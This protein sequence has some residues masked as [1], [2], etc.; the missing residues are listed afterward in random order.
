MPKMPTGESSASSTELGST[1]NIAVLS[2]QLAAAADLADS[3]IFH[4]DLPRDVLILDDRAAELF[5]FGSAGSQPFAPLALRRFPIINRSRVLTKIRCALIRDGRAALSFMTDHPARGPRELRISCRSLGTSG[6]RSGVTRAVTDAKL[7]NLQD[8]LMRVARLTAV[9]ELNMALAHELNQPL[10]AIVNH[11]S[12]AKYLVGKDGPVARAHLL[13]AITDATEQSMRAGAILKRL[14]TFI[15]K[16]EADKRLEAAS[17][18]VAEAVALLTSAI[19]KRGIDLKIENH[20]GD[21]SV[22]ADRVQIQQVLFNLL[23]NA[24]EALDAPGL[25]KRQLTI[26]TLLAASGDVEIVV[27]DTGPGVNADKARNLF[28]PFL[29]D[30]SDGMGV[31]LA[32]S[33]R[34]VEAHGGQL[35]Y[36]PAKG[37]GAAFR[38]TLPA[39]FPEEMI[40]E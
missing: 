7:H 16:G 4:W 17:T 30:K 19:R 5:G 3:G 22:L 35:T 23:R 1:T 29:S 33:K 12:A 10:G 9:G 8:D 24:M 21:V 39:P 2:A 34:I 31:G 28:L 14:R 18:I 20:A 13:Q 40:D 25:E 37:S 6:P 15:E 32:I 11:L 36:E 38:L 26:T 27:R